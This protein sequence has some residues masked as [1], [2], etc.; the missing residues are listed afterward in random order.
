MHNLVMESETGT[1]VHLIGQL[2][3]GG[4]EKQLFWLATALHQRGW[5]QSIVS[6]NPGGVWKERLESA[7]LVAHEI[8]RNRFKP[9]RLWRLAR[10]LGKERPAILHVWSSHVAQY[11]RWAWGKGAAKTVYGIRID[12]TVD[13]VTGEPIDR[14]PFLASLVHADC[15]VS[16]S[17]S[18]LDS[19]ARRGIKLPRAEVIWNIVEPHGRE[20]LATAI[21]RIVG[22]GSLIPRKGYDCLLRA[23]AILVAEQR[24]FELLLAGE[25]ADRNHLE[26]LAAELKLDRCLRFL[27][28]TDGV[29][30]LLATADI[31]VHPSKREGLSNTILEGMA[32]G[33]PVVSTVE[34]A[35][36]IIQD[37]HTGL[38]VSA[39]QPAALADAIRR[40]LDNPSLR[41]HLGAAALRFIVQRCNVDFITGQYEN[42]YRSLLA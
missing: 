27:G 11:A 33:L 26:S 4:A 15:A 6:F 8:P 42:V 36:E 23:A 20:R 5:R 22:V 12:M 3:R 7:G 25:G 18:A 10:I 31:L 37:G 9:G 13:A 30:D 14:I 40:L 34:C 39:G 24:P 41:A 28:A 32:E 38:L 16:N 1:I 35:S 19:L 17:Q 21:P 29:S 2:G